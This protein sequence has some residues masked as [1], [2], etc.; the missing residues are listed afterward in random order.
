MSNFCD[1]R[2]DDALRQIARCRPFAADGREQ[3]VQAVVLAV[4]DQ[5]GAAAGAVGI[6][7]AVID[8]WTQAGIEILDLVACQMRAGQVLVDE[9]EETCDVA[10]RSR[11]RRRDAP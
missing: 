3:T 1:D 11:R 7:G 8:Q 6:A 2:I 10:L 5:F 9:G 4:I